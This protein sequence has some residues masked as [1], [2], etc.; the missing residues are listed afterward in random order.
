MAGLAADEL[1]G[2]DIE[3]DEESDGTDGRWRIA[4]RVAEDRIISVHDPRGAAYL[5]VTLGPA[6]WSPRPRGGRAGNRH[7]HREKFTKAAGYYAPLR[8]TTK[9]VC[10]VAGIP[11]HARPQ[12]DRLTGRGLGQHPLP[13]FTSEAALEP[14]GSSLY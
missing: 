3:P 8:M 14:G 7:R 4:R 5:Q 13:T 6:G 1:P 10:R 11:S 2:Q 9:C 12:H